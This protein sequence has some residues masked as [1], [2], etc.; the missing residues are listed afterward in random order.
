MSKEQTALPKEH[1]AYSLPLSKVVARVKIMM[2]H[3][4]DFGSYL[5]ITEVLVNHRKAWVGGSPF[6]CSFPSLDDSG[7]SL[8]QCQ[9]ARSLQ[10]TCCQVT[11]MIWVKSWTVTRMGKGEGEPGGLEKATTAACIWLCIR[12]LLLMMQ[13]GIWLTDVIYKQ[14]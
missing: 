7:W 13:K 14:D 8:A 11:G 10:A 12:A 5:K 2:T 3:G 9:K 4:A 6:T 1:A